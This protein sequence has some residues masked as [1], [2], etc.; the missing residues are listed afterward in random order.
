MGLGLGL[1][2]VR[3]IALL[4]IHQCW[5]CP[6]PE[7]KLVDKNSLQVVNRSTQKYSTA[8]LRSVSAGRLLLLL[9]HRVYVDVGEGSGPPVLQLVPP[10]WHFCLGITLQV[11]GRSNHAAL[12]SG[13][14]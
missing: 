11:T 9:G 7:M 10:Q 3:G 14:A 1:A 12:V 8:L 6:S 2:C 13:S 4:Q 5:L